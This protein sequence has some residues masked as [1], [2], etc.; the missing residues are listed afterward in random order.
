MMSSQVGK[1]K[2]APTGS[3]VYPKKCKH[4]CKNLT[5][6]LIFPSQQNPKKL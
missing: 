3:T 6:K 2:L 4:E 1:K 5:Q